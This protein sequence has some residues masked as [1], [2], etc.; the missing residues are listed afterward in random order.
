MKIPPVPEG[1]RKRPKK[2]RGSTN[3]DRRSACSK[4]R[5][6]LF[7]LCYQQIRSLVPNQKMH[8]NK[9]M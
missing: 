8:F 9:A 6:R 1:K 2:C 7:P 3:E 4:H 5:D